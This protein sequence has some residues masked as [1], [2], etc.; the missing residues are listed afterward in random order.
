[1]IFSQH[2]A[3]DPCRLKDFVVVFNEKVK[4]LFGKN[5]PK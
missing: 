4:G 2:T 1:M 3:K 5:L